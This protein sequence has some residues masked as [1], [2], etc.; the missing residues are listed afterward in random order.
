MKKYNKIDVIKRIEH[1]AYKLR[2]RRQEGFDD[3][4]LESNSIVHEI[5]Y[6]FDMLDSD[7][8]SKILDKRWLDE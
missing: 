6:L 2:H 4:S 1:Q 3:D 8:Q 7:S 5:K